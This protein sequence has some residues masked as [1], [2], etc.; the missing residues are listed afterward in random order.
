MNRAE[1]VGAFNAQVRQSTEPDGTGATFEADEYVVRRYARPGHGGSGVFWSALDAEVAD[2]VIAAQVS[3]FAARGEEFEWKLYGYDRPADLGARLVAAGFVPE[4][5]ESLMVGEVAQVRQLLAGAQLPPG[6]RFER[7]TEP[8][9]AELL[10]RVHETVF[11]GDHSELRES[12]RAQLATAPGLIALVAVMAG[13]QPVCSGR[14]EFVPGTQFAGLWGGGT[15]PE[16][17]GRGIYR[18]LVRYRAEIAAS[19]GCAYLTVDATEQSRPILERSGFERV[20]VTT[21]YLWT[22]GQAG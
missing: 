19:R 6:V 10:T 20:A 12:V 5:P 16:W 4:Q 14:I 9:A 22:P 21:P 3:L 11:G 2:A 7:I 18:A 15:V 17:R 13:D 1:V 8:S